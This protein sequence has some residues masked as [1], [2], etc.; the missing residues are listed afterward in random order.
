[1]NGLILLLCLSSIPDRPAEG[2]L[3]PVHRYELPQ[4][5]FG[6]FRERPYVGMYVNVGDTS[7]VWC[8]EYRRAER[9]DSLCVW[10]DASRQDG[11]GFNLSDWSAWRHCGGEV[12]QVR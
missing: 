7:V 1:M 8:S 9:I 5:R 6:R 3:P 2:H 10:F 11:W 4:I 12:Y